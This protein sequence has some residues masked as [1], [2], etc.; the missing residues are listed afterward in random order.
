MILPW[1]G[2]QPDRTKPLRRRVTEPSVLVMP[3]SHYAEAEVIAAAHHP[4]WRWL[5]RG[6]RA[7]HTRNVGQVL[8]PLLN[9]PLELTVCYTRGGCG[10]GGT[11]QALRISTARGIPIY[12]LG[13][14]DGWDRLQAVLAGIQ[15]A[16]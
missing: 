16:V 5:K 12:D 15:V 10:A 14:P 8:G 6:P 1:D 3:L 11:G 2:F 7:M 13:A 4:A 9:L